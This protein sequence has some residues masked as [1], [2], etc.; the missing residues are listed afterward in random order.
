V[1]LI[2]AGHLV[3][4]AGAWRTDRL[5]HREA[6]AWLAQHAHENEAV[7]DTRG[8]TSL[9]SGRATYPYSRAKTALCDP[10]LGYVVIESRELAYDSGRARTLRYLLDRAARPVVRFGDASVVIYR[11]DSRRFSPRVCDAGRT[12]EGEVLK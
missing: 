4:T 6:G 1:G 9:Y 10:T 11:W 3:F 12:R 8:W 2:V 5:A 7:L